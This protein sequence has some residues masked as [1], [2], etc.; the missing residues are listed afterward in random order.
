MEYGRKVAIEGNW[1]YGFDNLRE[2][3]ELEIVRTIEALSS[4]LPS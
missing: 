4:Y 2:S 1:S 3:S